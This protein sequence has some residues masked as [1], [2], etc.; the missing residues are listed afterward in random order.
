MKLIY[1]NSLF[2]SIHSE[3]YE[4]NIS[5]TPL[6]LELVHNTDDDSLLVLLIQ[7]MN[8]PKVLELKLNTLSDYS[9]L[10]LKER[11]GRTTEN[12]LRSVE[13]MF[14]SLEFYEIV[15]EYINKCNKEK[16]AMNASDN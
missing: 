15:K 1:A 14:R 10:I 2:A 6:F 16:L 4:F 12:L 13:S 5:E 8:S 3:F 7:D 9:W 11:Y